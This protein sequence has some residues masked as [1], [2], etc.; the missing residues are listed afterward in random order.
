MAEQDELQIRIGLSVAGAEAVQ[1]RAHQAN[2]QV[3]QVDRKV[4]AAQVNITDAESR[5]NAAERKITKLAARAA[6]GIGIDMGLD[7]VIPTDDQNSISVLGRT[8]KAVAIPAMM[9]PNPVGWTIALISGAITLAQA[10]INRMEEEIKQ[11]REQGHDFRQELARI[12][13][14][15]KESAVKSLKSVE[16]LKAEITKQLY[17]EQ[18][19]GL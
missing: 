14:V 3:E 10:G 9:S 7:A 18:R 4:K 16:E 19:S 17:A 5:L 1:N 15:G 12:E 11:I 6:L 2:V 13:Q 8:V